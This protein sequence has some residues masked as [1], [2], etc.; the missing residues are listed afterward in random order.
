MTHPDDDLL[1][2][3]ALDLLGDEERQALAEHL[4]VCE[5]CRRR[6][7]AVEHEIEMIGDLAPD[8]PIP[9]VRMP[10]RRSSRWQAVVGI[11]AALVIGVFLGYGLSRIYGPSDYM[12]VPTTNRPSTLPLTVRQFTPCD[13]V[14]LWTS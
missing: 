13:P 2:K 9:R 7:L 8:I 6:L 5:P 1:L 4:S 10:V 3:R 11:A 14:N 12:V